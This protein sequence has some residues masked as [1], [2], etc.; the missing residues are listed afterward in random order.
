LLSK[1]DRAE[2]RGGVTALR[3]N[4]GFCG[5]GTVERSDGGSYTTGNEKGFEKKILCKA[6]RLFWNQLDR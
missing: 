4:K 3:P 6:K 5:D 2:F 1:A